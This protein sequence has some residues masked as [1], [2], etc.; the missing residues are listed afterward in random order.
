MEDYEFNSN[1]NS[2]CSYYIYLSQTTNYKDHSFKNRRVEKEKKTYFYSNSLF[3]RPDKP[4]LLL[5]YPHN[6]TMLQ[7]IIS[8]SQTLFSASYFFF[9]FPHP[10]FFTINIHF[11][12]NNYI[13]SMQWKCCLH[14]IGQV[15]Y[16]E[17][18]QGMYWRTYILSSYWV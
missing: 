14:G 5:S 13:L 12:F 15:C 4:P 10:T 3:R 16:E 9:E 6:F 11:S 18:I 1:R 2:L 8:L 7:V 17:T